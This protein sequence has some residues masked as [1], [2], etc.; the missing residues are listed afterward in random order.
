MRIFFG[1][2]RSEH[3]AASLDLHL[4]KKRSVLVSSSDANVSAAVLDAAAKT[5][6]LARFARTARE[7]FRVLSEHRSDLDVV[8]VDL[9]EP[10]THALAI[11]SA[12]DGCR[13]KPPVIALTALELYYVEP[14]VRWYGC[15]DCLAKPILSES[16]VK[17]IEKAAAKTCSCFSVRVRPGKFMVERCSASG[18]RS[19]RRQPAN[20]QR[21]HETVRER[22]S[23]NLRRVS[24]QMR[25]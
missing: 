15:I 18:S 4:M 17:A 7:A 14:I 3:A 13:E 9:D 5:Q 20:S 1:Q 10:M 22:P 11:L 19:A 8:I 23:E 12:V 6:R 2:M 25:S 16:L 21:R 24:G